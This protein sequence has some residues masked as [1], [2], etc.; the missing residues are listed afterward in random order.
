MLSRNL[1]CTLAFDSFAKVKEKKKK[2]SEGE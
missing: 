1:N 2:E